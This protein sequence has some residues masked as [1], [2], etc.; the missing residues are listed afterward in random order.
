MRLLLA[1]VALTASA[2]SPLARPL[3][4]D[5][6]V[7]LWS[8][9][10]VDL[11]RDYQRA[12]REATERYRGDFPSSRIIVRTFFVG[13]GS[14]GQRIEVLLPPLKSAGADDPFPRKRFTLDGLLPRPEAREPRL[15]LQLLDI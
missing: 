2:A 10:H 5:F 6:D 14:A 4:G 7:S 11:S 3:T 15:S 13:V 9:S 1:I 8:S 12:I